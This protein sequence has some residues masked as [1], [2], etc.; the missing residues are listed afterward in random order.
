MRVIAVVVEPRE[1]DGVKD[2]LKEEIRL[3]RVEPL[4]VST[5]DVLELIDER[6]PLAPKVLLVSHERKTHLQ[7]HLERKSKFYSHY[8]YRS[9]CVCAFVLLFLFRCVLASL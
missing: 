8:V 9:Q 7:R 1:K 4:L 2:V 6:L 5:D 3:F